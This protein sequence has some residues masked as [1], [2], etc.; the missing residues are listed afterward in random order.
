M[1]EMAAATAKVKPGGFSDK[2]GRWT[3]VCITPIMRP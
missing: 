3:A 1:N 2:I